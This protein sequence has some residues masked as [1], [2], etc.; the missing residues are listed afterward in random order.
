M[1]HLRTAVLA[2]AIA[3]PLSAQNAQPQGSAA[4]SIPQPG[5]MAPDF[6]LPIADASG[7]Q[8]P[9]SLSSLRGK[10]VVLAFYPADFSGGCTIQLSKYRDDYKTIFGDDVVVL[11]ISTDSLSTHERWAASMKF[12]FALGTDADGK[13]ASLYGSAIPGRGHARNLF[14]IGKDGRIVYSKAR[15]NVQA[16]AGYDEL[17]AA[18]AAAKK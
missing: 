1:R 3:A 17:A 5:A 11:P 14:V 9:V 4:P 12:P 6:T 2:L 15:V 10:V 8:A 7:T 13:V 16:Q 18:V